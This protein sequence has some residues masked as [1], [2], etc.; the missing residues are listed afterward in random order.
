MNLFDVYPLWNIEP[1]KG[2][3]CKIWDKEGK[4]YLDL[5]GGHAVISI[6]H[7]HPTYVKMV[8]EQVSN[9]GFYSEASVLKMIEYGAYPSFMVMGADNFSISDT[10]LEN[11]FSLNY[12][13]WKDRIEGV[14]KDVNE[15][16]SKVKGA[17][18]T[19]HKVVAEGVYVTDYENG[20]SIYVN[21]NNDE[22]VTEEGVTV[23][24]CGFAVEE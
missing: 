17:S 19:G 9:L 22:Y 14:Y 18:I 21:Y 5:Y 11:H 4:E 8:Q 23:P 13:D 16:L 3:G 2:L 15:A 20:T 6:G 10:P 7:S 12:E 24:G 1:V